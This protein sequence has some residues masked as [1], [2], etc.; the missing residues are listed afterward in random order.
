VKKIELI[1]LREGESSR[2]FIKYAKWLAYINSKQG[3]FEKA[4]E[5]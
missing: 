3:N 5:Y 1:I 4:I 2:I